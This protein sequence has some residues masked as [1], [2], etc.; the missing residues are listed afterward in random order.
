MNLTFSKRGRSP[1]KHDQFRFLFIATSLNKYTLISHPIL[2]LSFV[3]NETRR[4]IVNLPIQD[5]H[6]PPLLPSVVKNYLLFINRIQ[7]PYREILSP[8]F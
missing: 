4:K 2:G 5:T 1:R 3:D 7:G 6:D 8:S